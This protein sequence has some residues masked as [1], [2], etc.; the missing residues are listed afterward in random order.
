MKLKTWHL[1][2]IIIV[3]FGCSF[4][5]INLKFDKFYRLNG[6]N[7]DNRVLIEKYLDKDEQTYLI[8][9]QIQ[10]DLFIDYLKEDDF[11]LQ[12]YQYYNELK[13]TQRYSRVDD[14]LTV[15][16]SLATRLTYLYSDNAFQHAKELIDYSLETAFLN[17]ND[18]NNDYVELY[19]YMRPLYSIDDNSFVQDTATYV[20]RLQ[21]LGMSKQADLEQTFSQLTTAYTKSSLKHLM[22]ATLEDHQ[23]IV[24]NPYE[25]TTIVDENHYIGEYEPSSLLLT[26]D[27]P[28]VKYAMYLQSDAY[29]ALLKM[30]Q[31]LSKNHK[32]FLL[33]E[34]YISSQALSKKEVGYNEYQLG[35]SICVSQTGLSYKDFENSE[36][37]HWLEENAYQYGFI[38]RYPKN[39]ASITN[40]VYDSHVYRYVGKSLA[41][42]LYDS[43]LTLEEYLLIEK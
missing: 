21:E 33:K 2:A 23:R 16:N 1:F 41:K 42:S 43:N 30:Y 18:F 38:L 31:D 3:L 11:H 5:V 19:K 13:G 7:N 9:N 20:L 4:F 6:I 10:I 29:N 34:G 40:H 22:E 27:I 8:D 28:R 14:I 32:G 15:G 26:Q 12:N 25:L 24:F 39:K 37:S 35:L 17:E 36:L